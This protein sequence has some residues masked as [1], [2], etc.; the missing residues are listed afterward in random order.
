[1]EGCR[2]CLQKVEKRKD[3][4]EKKEVSASR[5]ESE[6]TLESHDEWLALMHGCGLKD[7]SEKKP[8]LLRPKKRR[9]HSAFV[10]AKANRASFKSGK[11]Q[12]YSLFLKTES[13]FDRAAC[14]KLQ[15]VRS[16]HSIPS[17][18]FSKNFL[19]GL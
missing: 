6:E 7:D 11:A 12:P 14:L 3:K 8:L 15:P 4:K 2:F 19:D 1:M 17:S 16:T 13:L 10:E 5:K 9:K 18:F